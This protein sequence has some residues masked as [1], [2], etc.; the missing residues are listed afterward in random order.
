MIIIILFKQVHFSFRLGLSTVIID[1][2]SIRPICP[3]G[4]LERL[5]FR[6][7]QIIFMMV[8]FVSIIC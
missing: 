8:G 4:A 2:Q 5:L 6:S 7:K 1:D 3:G